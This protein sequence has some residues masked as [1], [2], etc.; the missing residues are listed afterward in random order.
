MNAECCPFRRSMGLAILL[1]LVFTPPATPGEPA[2]DKKPQVDSRRAAEM[3]EAIV[4]RNKAPKLKEWPG[5]FPSQVA[6]Y[7]EDHDW[8]EEYRTR[9]AIYQLEKD[10]TEAVW[11]ELVKHADDHRYSDTVTS[12]K[13]GDA[14]IEDVGGT[15]GW[16]AKSRLIDVFRQ[17]LPPDPIKDF[18]KLSL[19][20][21][22]KDLTKWRK[23]R[24]A[25]SLYELQIEVCEKAIE[26]LAK[27]QGVPQAEKDK[28]RKKIEQEIA[29][30]RKSKKPVHVEASPSF[31]KRGQYKAEFAKRVRECINSGKY[32]D[33]DITDK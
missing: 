27:V 10:R 7:S 6:L 26:A 13:T 28:A 19:D 14:Y 33:L 5:N 4:N 25:K 29:S 3:V 30:L 1:G 21:G 12:M 11:E 8:K 18:D 15:C 22:I 24:A 31:L 32:E 16:L 20:V 9:T 23:E 2:E 17:H